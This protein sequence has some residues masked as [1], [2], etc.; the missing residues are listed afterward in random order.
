MHAGTEE[1][2][3]LNTVVLIDPVLAGFDEKPESHSKLL[4]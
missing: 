2:T 4:H 3:G 1:V